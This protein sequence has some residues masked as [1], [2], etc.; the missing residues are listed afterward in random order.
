MKPLCEIVVSQVLPTIRAMVVKD[1]IK[2][3]KMSQVDVARKLGITQPAVS[4]YMGSLRGKGATEKILAKAV[5]K[6]IK[7]LSDDI[8]SGKLKQ[9]D[10]IKKYCEIC[11]FMKK[12]GV[13]GNFQCEVLE[14]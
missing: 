14:L 6:E 2:R 1:L 10:V 11:K 7:D 12:K 5:G 13:L 8:A 3:Y 4:Q 9:G